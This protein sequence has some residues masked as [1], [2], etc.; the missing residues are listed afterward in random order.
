MKKVL[1]V[2]LLGGFSFA[3]F[4]HTHAQVEQ[5]EQLA[6]DIEK[7]A[8]MKSILKDMYKYYQILSQGYDE[9]RSLAQGNFSL[10]QGFLNSLL[11]VSPAVKNYVRVVDIITDEATL[12]SEYKAALSRFQHANV[13]NPTELDYITGI[14]SNLFN[15]SL[16]DIDELTTVLTDGQLRASDAER[17][18]TIDQLYNDME[19]KLKFLRGFNNNTGLLAAQRLQGS[20]QNNTLLSLYGN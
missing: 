7:L 14:Y 6:L 17:L 18:N 8:Q 11:A 16:N 19:A 1:F 15:Q 13:F 20:Q 5:L 2:V 10:H 9:V 12:V 3:P 4:Q